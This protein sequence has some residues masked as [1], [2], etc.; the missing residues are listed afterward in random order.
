MSKKTLQ[1]IIKNDLIVIIIL[2]L[3]IVT[4]SLITP[5]NSFATKETLLVFFKYSP[6]IALITLGM[7]IVM[8]VGEF[9]LS[10][11]SIYVL[12]S[13]IFAYL[14]KTFNMHFALAAG[15]TLS[16]GCLLGFINGFLLTRTKITSFIVTLGTNWAFRGI[17]LVWV[18][19]GAI[20]ISLSESEKTISNVFTGNIMGVPL[21]FIWLLITTWILW[22]VLHNTKLGVWIF[23]TGSNERAGRMMGVNTDK[24][25][26]IS[27]VV[28]GFLCSLAGFLQ[29]S[30]MN[31]AIPQS[32]ETVMLVSI[33]GAIIGG[34]SLNGGRGGVLGA[35]LG[36]FVYQTISLGFIMLG[37]I[38]YYTNIVMAVALIAISSIYNYANRESN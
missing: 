24:V 21:Q 31:H 15:I 4:F 19:G 38:E 35:L 16:C 10:V 1:I 3:L 2:F 25:K 28:C 11:G 6:E 8:I 32:G 17:M 9:D 34:I 20:K 30:R 29:V 27:F 22:V 14:I 13:V 18:G 33:A 23:T 12:S 5:N 26:I 7:G 36:A 37:L